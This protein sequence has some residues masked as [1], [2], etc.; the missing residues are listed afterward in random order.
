MQKNRKENPPSTLS[1]EERKQLKRQLDYVE[2][3]IEKFNAHKE[4]IELKM[5]QPEV[6]NSPEFSELSQEHA[7]LIQ[8]I[9]DKEKEWEQLVTQLDE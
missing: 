6:M 8:K 4:G 5:A 1:Y 9:Q 3:D 7:S 2:R